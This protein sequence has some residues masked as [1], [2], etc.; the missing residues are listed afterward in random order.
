MKNNKHLSLNIRREHYKSIMHF[1][2]LVIVT[3]I[4]KIDNKQGR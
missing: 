2:L 3:K 1:L 4:D